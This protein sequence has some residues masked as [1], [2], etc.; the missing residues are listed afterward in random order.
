[1]KAGDQISCM[2]A[3]ANT[4]PCF[5]ESRLVAVAVD[6]NIYVHIGPTETC[7]FRE[8]DLCSLNGAFLEK[9]PGNFQP[10]KSLEF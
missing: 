2:L 5:S 7:N 10:Q 9:N 3:R 6:S 4:K 8:K 1:M